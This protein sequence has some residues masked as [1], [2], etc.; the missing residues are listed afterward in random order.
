MSDY[1]SFDFEPLPPEPGKMNEPAK[2]FEMPKR[3]PVPEST[4]SVPS[5][6]E[7]E[8]ECQYCGMAYES[9]ASCRYCASNYK[10]K[11][12]LKK[13]STAKEK[14]KTPSPPLTKG[15]RVRAIMDRMRSDPQYEKIKDND[16]A[17]RALAE[18][19]ESTKPGTSHETEP[20]PPLDN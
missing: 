2:V 10:K 15:Q 13:K 17:L 3:G 12:Y 7:G 1:P 20:W 14:E 4:P 6:S 11:D 16:N 18:I 8:D 19:I 5:F 9:E